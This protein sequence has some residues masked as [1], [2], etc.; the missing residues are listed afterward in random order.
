VRN[1]LVSL[2]DSERHPDV[3]KDLRGRLLRSLTK[4]WKL[5]KRTLVSLL[6]VDVRTEAGLFLEKA[7]AFNLDQPQFDR[8]FKRLARGL[9]FSC[10]KTS[11]ADCLVNW[12]PV[13]GANAAGL[14]TQLH[15][16]RPAYTGAVGSR[17]FD[18][19]GFVKDPRRALSLWIVQFYGGPV[20]M[21]LLHPP[22]RRSPALSASP[23]SP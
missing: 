16:V 1:I 4:D 6:Q 9:L 14:E 23:R 10:T 11:F 22:P 8:F 7:A 5:F 15:G 13:A 19:L 3:V 18:Y 21:M 17:V 12:R 20:F 2:A